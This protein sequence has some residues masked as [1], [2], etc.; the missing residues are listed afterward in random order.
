MRPARAATASSRPSALL[1]YPALKSKFA[2]ARQAARHA[3]TRPRT[4]FDRRGNGSLARPRRAHA[5]ASQAAADAPEPTEK[6]KPKKKLILKPEDRINL[7]KQL[8]P[9]LKPQLKSLVDQL[10]KADQ[11][12]YEILGRCYGLVTREV[13]RP[14]SCFRL[15]FSFKLPSPHLVVKKIIRNPKFGLALKDYSEKVES[16]EDR[17]K[18]ELE[19]DCCKR[20]CFPRREYKSRA[21]LVKELDKAKKDL[22][23]EKGK[24][25]SQ[26]TRTE[27]PSAAAPAPAPAPAGAPYSADNNV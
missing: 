9:L 19:E 16:D 20:C 2:G 15:P 25:P 7:A 18:R 5:R 6:E 10:E 3:A 24:K 22:A 13:M 26:T 4:G 27:P 21:E 12:K 8:E 17:R 14:R 1:Q 23:K 11:A